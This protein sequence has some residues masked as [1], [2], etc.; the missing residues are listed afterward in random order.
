MKK[1]TK[2]SWYITAAV[3]AVLV[4]ICVFCFW[5]WGQESSDLSFQFE[6]TVYEYENEY[7]RVEDLSYPQRW[8]VGI[9]K[10]KAKSIS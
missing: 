3:M 2:K 7:C 9:R 10:R 4:M 5:R 6:E 1:I 8:G